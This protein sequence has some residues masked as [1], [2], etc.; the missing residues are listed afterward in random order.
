M[1][2]FYAS[3]AMLVG[4]AIIAV[5]CGGGGTKTDEN[6]RDVVEWVVRAGGTVEIDGR[7]QP[8]QRL[9]EIPEGLVG[10]RSID[11]TGQ[12]VGDEDL[13]R[14]VGLGGITELL[15]YQT[16]VTDDGLD[17]IAKIRSLRTL[18]LSYTRVTDD[19]LAK[20][21]ALPRLRKLYLRQTAVSDD[22]VT[23][24]EDS[25]GAEVVR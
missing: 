4:I 9:T 16:R 19:G 6:G 11:L 20:L 18:N 3:R 5:G 2:S 25:T 22:A 8:I 12:D 13:E 17:S 15:L 1:P 10:V 24:L 14:L 21:S 7:S 23:S